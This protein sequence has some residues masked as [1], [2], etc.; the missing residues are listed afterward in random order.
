MKKFKFKLEKILQIKKMK[1][2][3]KFA[4]LAS[5]IQLKNKY[6]SFIHQGNEV[7]SNFR[8]K[9]TSTNK[10]NVAQMG[11]FYNYLQTINQRTSIY[12]R[13][14]NEISQELNPHLEDLQQLKKERKSLEIL[15]EKEQEKHKKQLEK[16]EVK[17]LDEF[18]LASF[19]SKKKGK[20]CN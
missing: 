15:K 19:T 12:K 11:Q 10:E 18:N 7:I 3:L 4:E 1:E 6:E 20:I 16:E 14:L 8:N 13:K 2:D 9:N 17:E 5:S